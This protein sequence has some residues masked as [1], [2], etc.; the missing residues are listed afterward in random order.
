MNKYIYIWIAKGIG[1][2]TPRSFCPLSLS[3]TFSA[4]SRGLI[5]AFLYGIPFALH[6]LG[7]AGSWTSTSG[8]RR[9]ST[10]SAWE[11]QVVY[12]ILLAPLPS[13]CPGDPP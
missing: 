6:G 9:T 8:T 1:L 10:C 5:R 11:L 3:G 4:G 2:R 7:L 12:V 13:L